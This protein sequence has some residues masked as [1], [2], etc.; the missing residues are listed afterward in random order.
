M[1]KRGSCGIIATAIIRAEVRIVL[2]YHSLSRSDYGIIVE[3]VNIVDEMKETAVIFSGAKKEKRTRNMKQ[4][5]R[6]VCTWH[7]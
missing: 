2:P 7:I 4:Q 1:K 6:R 3:N 5:E